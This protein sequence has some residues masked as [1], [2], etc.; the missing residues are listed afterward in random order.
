MART[1]SENYDTIQRGILAKAAQVFAAQGYMRA[2]VADLTRACRLSRGALY[3][4]FESKEA[5]LFAILDAHVRERAPRPSHHGLT[6]EEPS[7][8]VPVN[9]RIRG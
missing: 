4:Y 7:W 6:I 2:S 3:H 5:I 8:R 1:R 9:Q